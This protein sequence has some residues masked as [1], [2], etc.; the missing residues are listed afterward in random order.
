[1]YDFTKE[2]SVVRMFIIFTRE[3]PVLLIMPLQGRE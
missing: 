1:M 2:A 3:T